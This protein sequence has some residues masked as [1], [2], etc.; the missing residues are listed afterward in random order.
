VVL[1][2]T[3]RKKTLIMVYDI[4]FALCRAHG[5][6][7]DARHNFFLADVIRHAG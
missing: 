3:A 2:L 6:N 7:M 4:E 1:R 5:D